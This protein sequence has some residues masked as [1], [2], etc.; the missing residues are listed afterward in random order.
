MEATSLG[1]GIAVVIFVALAVVL[2]R[3]VNND[4]EQTTSDS[5]TIT[6]E[7]TAPLTEVRD[8]ALKTAEADASVTVH[9]EQEATLLEGLDRTCSPP[10]R[11]MSRSSTNL[12]SCS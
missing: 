12:K 2:I 7:T 1:I 5:P 3:K 4:N 11:M 10:S 8:E 9:A 6:S